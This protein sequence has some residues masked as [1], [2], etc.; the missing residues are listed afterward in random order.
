MHEA[1]RV[2]VADDFALLLPLMYG[3]YSDDGLTFVD[4]NASAMKR[5]L[6]E[7]QWGAVLL[8][9]VQGKPVGYVVLC[10]G[11]S[12]ELGGSEAFVDELYVHPDFRK[13]G[14]AQRLLAEVEIT[15][16]E[17]GVKALHLEVDPDNRVAQSLYES[18]NYT[19][20]D[21][22]LLMTKMLNR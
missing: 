13:Q 22:Y 12:V 6:S 16:K 4:T 3:Y 17:R 2:A 11:F 18:R 19:K 10:I 1:I 7:P 20:R 14:I 9:T 8:A 15:A 21:R 5:L